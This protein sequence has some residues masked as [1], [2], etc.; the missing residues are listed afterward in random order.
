MN[1]EAAV[2]NQIT[3]ITSLTDSARDSIPLDIDRKLYRG[4]FGVVTWHA[5]RQVQKHIKSVSL[6]LRPCTGAFTRGMGLPCAHICDIK[7][8][9]TGLTPSDFHEHWY[10]DRQNTLRPL[11]DPLR[12]RKQGNSAVTVRTDRNTGRILSAGEEQPARKPPMCTACYTRGHKRTSPNCPLKLQA[13]I[14]SQSQILRD[15]GVSQSQ[16]IPPTISP[17]TTISITASIP[18]VSPLTDL[19]T[20]GTPFTNSQLSVN[21]HVS[22]Q[23]TA[24]P[25]QN[26]RAPPTIPESPEYNYEYNYDL[27]NQLLS[28]DSN[29]SKPQTLALQPSKPLSPNRPEVLLQSYLAEKEAWLAAHPSIRPTEYR[30]ARGW[31]TFRPKILKEQLRYMPKERRDLSG[32]IVAKKANWTSEEILVWLD[33][34]ERLEEELDEQVQSDFTLNRNRHTL[35]SAGDVWKAVRQEQEQEKEQYII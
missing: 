12:V 2:I 4:V 19:P 7:R 29:T 10:W 20:V 17:S 8:N 6:P 3:S 28:Y 22:P 33:N 11:L 13:S 23:Q 16:T 31:K 35:S 30:K 32:N 9:T 25:Q 14:A 21:L 24:S 18:A 26:F 34:E 15:L 5:I 27:Y 1:I